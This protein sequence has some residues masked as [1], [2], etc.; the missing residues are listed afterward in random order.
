MD[1]HELSA[2]I[3]YKTSRSSGSGGQQ[4]NKVETRVELLFD[5]DACTLLTD[6]E[7]ELVLLRCKNRIN[8]AGVLHMVS[9]K[10]RTQLANKKLVTEKFFM[11]IAKSLEPVK[12]RR[13]TRVPAEEKENR[14]RDKKI[15]ST[16]KENRK[17]VHD[18]NARL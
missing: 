9:Q 16:I 13:A 17:K 3:S 6:T 15:K 4:V 5:L 7:K 10:E 8:A 11:L 2:F 14:I 12:K 18:A 1:L